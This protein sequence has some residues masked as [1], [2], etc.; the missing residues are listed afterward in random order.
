MKVVEISKPGDPSV[1][2]LR[3][4]SD[5]PF[6]AGEVLI[7][8]EG[9]GI[10]RPDILQRKGLYPPPPG[11]SDIPG[12]EVAGI[13]VA[14]DALAMEAAGLVAG[15]AVCALVAGGG[16]ASLC[17]AAAD[18]CLPV[19][20]GWTMMEAAAFPEAAFTVWSNV[21]DRG[22]LKSGETILI[23][24]GSSGIGT[25]AI[26]MAKAHG[27]R[28]IVTVGS[29]AKAQ[30][31]LRLGADHVIL[32][33]EEDFSQAVL[34]MTDGWGADVILDM[35]AGDYIARNLSCLADDGRL[36]IIAVQGGL[37]AQFNAATVMRRRLTIT[38]ST[39]RPRSVA[40]KA[41]IARSLKKDLWPWMDALKVR[42]VIDRIYEAAD[43]ACA[44][45]TLE[46]GEHIGKLV[47]RWPGAQV[48]ANAGPS[49][50]NTGLSHV[51]GHPSQ[52]I[53]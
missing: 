39:L 8:V 22:A 17:V 36:L 5:P 15:Q 48:Q 45:E 2:R 47:L 35:V 52:R 49:V 43:A 25:L 9:S 19:P 42:P 30:A 4:Q 46:A 11:V 33:K 13:I 20:A 3:E 38:G 1:L 32:Y 27:C 51:E 21:F 7:Q 37:R 44:H 14:G 41:A 6:G 34:G 29:T 16:Y 40:F 28:V 31:C 26:Q 10:N 50:H 53:A 23:H 12:L 24:G 18:L